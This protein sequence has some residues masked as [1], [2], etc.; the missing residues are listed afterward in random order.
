MGRIIKLERIV[1]TGLEAE[2]RAL[3]DEELEARIAK[4]SGVSME[5]VRVEQGGDGSAARLRPRRSS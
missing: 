1:P 2:L 5:E 3:S 4:L